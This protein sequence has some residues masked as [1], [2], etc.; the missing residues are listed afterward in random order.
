MKLRRAGD[1]VYVV[2]LFIKNGWE[3]LTE[4]SNFWSWLITPG[5]SVRSM[6]AVPAE[7]GLLLSL[8]SL[9]FPTEHEVPSTRG[10]GRGVLFSPPTWSGTISVTELV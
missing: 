8:A 10:G 6:C 1:G 5:V 2:L 9:S 7:G 4:K 3:R